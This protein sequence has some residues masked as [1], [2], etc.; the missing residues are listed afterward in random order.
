MPRT[1]CSIAWPPQAIKPATKKNRAPRPTKEAKTK[2]NK[3]ILAKPA[4]MV[5]TL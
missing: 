3:A 2:G 5:K 1:R 4:A